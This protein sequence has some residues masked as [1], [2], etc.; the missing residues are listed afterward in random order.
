MAEDETNV[1]AQGEEAP[2]TAPAF[3]SE[4]IAAIAEAAAKAVDARIPGLMSVQDKKLDALVKKLDEST[5][6][7]DELEDRR[8][9]ETEQAL[10]K[11]QRERDVLL[12]GQQ[13]P[14][15]LPVFQEISA[16]ETVDDQLAIIDK[17]LAGQQAPAEEAQTATE[18]TSETQQAAPVDLNNPPGQ[19]AGIPGGQMNADLANRILDSLPTWP[20]RD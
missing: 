1:P 4:Q 7:E 12:A 19:G 9:S 16:A 8:L 17:L 14:N 3:S 11:A 5:M 20:G 18:E 13:H 10:A 15:A 2:A 6:D